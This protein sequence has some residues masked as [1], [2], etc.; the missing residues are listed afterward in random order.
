MGWKSFL[1]VYVPVWLPFPLFGKRRSRREDRHT[2][3]E[4]ETL[5][6][7]RRKEGEESTGK[8][9]RKERGGK[10]KEKWREEVK[11]K[12]RVYATSYWL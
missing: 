2:E 8:E 6:K 5:E 11:V 7:K 10:H 9:E 1:L 3:G 12:D 4:K